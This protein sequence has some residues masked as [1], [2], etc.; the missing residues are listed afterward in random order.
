MQEI[1]F[2]VEQLNQILNQLSE[3]PYK[4]SAGIVQMIQQIA[5]EQLRG[6]VQTPPQEASAE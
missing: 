3:M 1:K 2:T 6:D 5:S 4:F